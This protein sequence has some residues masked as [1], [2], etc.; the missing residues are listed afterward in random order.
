MNKPIRKAASLLTALVM[1]T[2]AFL[3]TITAR[4]T[5]PTSTSDTLSRQMIN[6]TSVTHV[7]STTLPAFATGAHVIF[8]YAS[9][10]FSAL[11]QNGATGACA[12][13]TCTL[14][15]SATDVQIICTAGPCSGLY[16]QTGTFTATN[17]GSAG[18][19]TVS[20]SSNGG[21]VSGSF[22]I[23]IVDSDQVSI[24]ATV[25]PSITFDI[26]TGAATGAETAA[27]YT[28]ALGI[29]TPTDGRVTGSDDGVNFIGIDLNANASGG[30]VVQVKSTNGA[31]VSTSTPGDTIPSA[32]AA[33]S[34]GTSN[35]GICVIGSPTATVGT[36]NDVAPFIGATCAANSEVNTVGALTTSFQTIL[37]SDGTPIGTGRAEIA[38]SAA[39]SSS[40]AAHNDYADTLTFIATGTF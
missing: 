39:V 36:F 28:V 14:N 10:G 24:T 3:P 20:I 19:K 4:A 35:Y 27:P 23:P 21:P 15:V 25:S 26:D 7:L 40:Q 22:A 8:D 13:G 6:V 2:T 33:M 34:N 29:I 16:T 37:N 18:S 12:S 17:P 11:S 31:L 1:L 9:A 30:A 38:V 32:T 5:S